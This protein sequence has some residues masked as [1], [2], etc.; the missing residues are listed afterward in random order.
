MPIFV[1]LAMLTPPWSLAD[2]FLAWHTTYCHRSTLI[3][4]LF[5]LTFALVSI[6]SKIFV[7]TFLS[8]M[9]GAMK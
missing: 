3:N 8:I 5:Q 2:I 6:D 1:G 9:Y 4:I 7:V